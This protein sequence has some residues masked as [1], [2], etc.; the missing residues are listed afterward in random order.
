MCNELVREQSTWILQ[1]KGFLIDGVSMKQDN[2]E[3]IDLYCGMVTELLKRQTGAFWSGEKMWI[4]AEEKEMV[5]HARNMTV[6]GK[7]EDRVCR[8]YFESLQMR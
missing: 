5:L 6:F 2:R 8:G 7:L 3:E 1:N 4:W